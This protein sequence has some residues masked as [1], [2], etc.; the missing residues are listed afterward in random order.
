[1]ARTGES[2]LIHFDTHL[3]CWLYNGETAKLS[4]TAKA[5]IESATSLAI[6]P[7]VELELYFL[8][9]IGR[10][11][12]PPAEALRVMAEQFNLTISATPFRQVTLAA[13]SLSWTRDPFD[14][15]IAAHAIASGARLITKDRLILQHC[16]NAL[17]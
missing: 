4:A 12:H 1:M 7:V 2:A 5:T 16:P 17:W 8:H 3:V 15:L 11:L 9:E 14:R 6:S 13:H 10:F